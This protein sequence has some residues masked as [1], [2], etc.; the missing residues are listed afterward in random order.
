[1]FLHMV[2]QLCFTYKEPKHT[3]HFVSLCSFC[4]CIK[5]ASFVGIFPQTSYIFLFLSICNNGQGSIYFSQT[6][7]CILEISKDLAQH[8]CT[9]G[10][11][12]LSPFPDLSQTVTSGTFSLSFTCLEVLLPAEQLVTFSCIIQK[13]ISL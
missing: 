11:C 8:I 6:S 13:L 5:T 1:M 3:G 9:H 4:T 12:R 2:I 10:H 7:S